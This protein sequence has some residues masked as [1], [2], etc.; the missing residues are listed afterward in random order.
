MSTDNLEKRAKSHLKPILAFALAAGCGIGGYFIGV[1]EAEKSNKLMEQQH[2]FQLDKMKIPPEMQDLYIEAITNDEVR[3]QLKLRYD[4][5]RK[6][7]SDPL[8]KH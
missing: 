2:K 4:G 1:R 7:Y 3:A 8:F 6:I 5:S